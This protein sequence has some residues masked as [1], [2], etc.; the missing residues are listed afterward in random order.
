MLLAL[1]KQSSLPL[2]IILFSFISKVYYVDLGHIF[3][4]YILIIKG[5]SFSCSHF[6]ASLLDTGFFFMLIWLFFFF[7]CS[8][9]L[10][11]DALPCL[12]CCLPSLTV[13]F[14]LLS[15]PHYISFYGQEGR[16][17]EEQTAMNKILSLLSLIFVITQC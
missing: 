11:L 5:F 15:Q 8:S 12:S 9:F 16:R 13:P 1:V 17:K 4:F 7:Y 6:L 2:L 14:I 10:P 3:Q